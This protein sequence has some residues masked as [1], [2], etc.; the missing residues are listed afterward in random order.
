ML[1]FDSL[2]VTPGSQNLYQWQYPYPDS[3]DQNATWYQIQQLKTPEEQATGT[4]TYPGEL[5]W[6]D[7]GTNNAREMTFYLWL[8]KHMIKDEY[9]VRKKGDIVA[10]QEGDLWQS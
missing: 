4:E 6:G 10:E 8:L 2:I 9:L 3:V 1:V 5:R 7:L